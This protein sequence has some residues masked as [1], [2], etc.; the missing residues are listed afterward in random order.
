MLR[1]T[2]KFRDR[3]DHKISLGIYLLISESALDSFLTL[4]KERE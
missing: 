2:D 3:M 1:L 4:F